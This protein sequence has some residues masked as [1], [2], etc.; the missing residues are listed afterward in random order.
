VGC[1]TDMDCAASVPPTMVAPGV[2]ANCAAGK[3]NATIRCFA[4]VRADFAG[5]TASERGGRRQRGRTARR[6]PAVHG[7]SSGKPRGGPAALDGAS[8]TSVQCTRTGPGSES[9]SHPWR[10]RDAHQRRRSRS[11]EHTD[12]R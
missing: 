11:R 12:E 4:L 2:G 6:D 1:T 7:H 10:R 8:L 5:G 3:C 9:R